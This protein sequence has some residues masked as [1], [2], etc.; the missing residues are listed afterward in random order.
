MLACNNVHDIIFLFITLQ[1][2]FFNITYIQVY[3][4]NRIIKNFIIATLY[5][6]IVASYEN[7]LGRTKYSQ[8]EKHNPWNVS[9]LDRHPKI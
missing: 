5:S 2:D 6:F 4:L 8:F 7:K 3:L 1:F 9:C